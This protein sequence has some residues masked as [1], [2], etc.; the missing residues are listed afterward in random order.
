VRLIILN[1]IY[2]DND[3]EKMSL[4]VDVSYIDWMMR[5]IACQEN[6]I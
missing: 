2:Y 4:I 3:V 5:W 1:F 6:Y